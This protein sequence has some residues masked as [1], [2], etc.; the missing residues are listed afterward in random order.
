MSEKM[1]QVDRAM[2]VAALLASGRIE[3]DMSAKASVDAFT[4]VLR[5]IRQR[6]GLSKIWGEVR[7]D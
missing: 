7:K 1:D 6:G 5:E 2:L 3:P 4:D